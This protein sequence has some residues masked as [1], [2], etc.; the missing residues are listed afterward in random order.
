MNAARLAGIADLDDMI[1]EGDAA[2]WHLNTTVH[3]DCDKDEG[4][5]EKTPEQAK[6]ELDIVAQEASRLDVDR[7]SKQ[8]DIALEIR[9]HLLE[10]ARDIRDSLARAKNRVDEV[11]ILDEYLREDFEHHL[12]EHPRSVKTQFTVDPSD[13]GRLVGGTTGGRNI[14]RIHLAHAKYYAKDTSK[15]EQ[16]HLLS[17]YMVILDQL[18]ALSQATD[19]WQEQVHD[20][21]SFVFMFE[22]TKRAEEMRHLFTKWEQIN[23]IDWRIFSNYTK[24]RKAKR[25]KTGSISGKDLGR[26]RE[27][28]GI[29]LPMSFN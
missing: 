16:R 26:P 18:V 24:K 3:T 20:S 12:V 19:M 1:Y 23:P 2:L 17:E 22:T 11:S 28:L 27:L 7:V 8:N 10:K 29:H 14:L 25:L 13:D 5:P 4:L 9:E 21:L 15:A 6:L